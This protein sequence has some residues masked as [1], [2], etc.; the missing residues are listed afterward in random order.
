MNA[1]IVNTEPCWIACLHPREITRYDDRSIESAK[2][3]VA[4]WFGQPMRSTLTHGA[5]LGMS[6]NAD[7]AIAEVER[8]LDE[9]YALPA[10]QLLSVLYPRS[11][12]GS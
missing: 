12:A 11:A 1:P 7:D 9:L 4:V 8:R 2:S 6:D 5:F 3:L 10:E